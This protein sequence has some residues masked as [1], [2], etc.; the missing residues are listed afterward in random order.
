MKALC[1]RIHELVDE[2]EDSLRES[3]RW[4]SVRRPWRA[5][6]CGPRVC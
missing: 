3:A 1:F 4:T 5:H 6:P 2:V